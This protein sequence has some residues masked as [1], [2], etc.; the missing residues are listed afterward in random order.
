MIEVKMT[1]TYYSS[2][3]LINAIPDT[4]DNVTIVLANV[5]HSRD[6]SANERFIT[7]LFYSCK[8]NNGSNFTFIRS[9]MIGTVNIYY[10]STIIAI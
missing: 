7:Y 9:P 8:I 4:T 5:A 2:E 6:V 10:I 1:S 3:Y